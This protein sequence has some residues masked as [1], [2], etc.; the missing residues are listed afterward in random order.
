VVGQSDLRASPPNALD[1]R[2][3]API[4]VVA[5]AHSRRPATVRAPPALPNPA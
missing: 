5:P 2:T 4:G 3:L 1:S